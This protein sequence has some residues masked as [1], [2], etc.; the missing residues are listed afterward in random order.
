MLQQ[1]KIGPKFL[2]L[3]T[4]VGLV[5]MAI[6]LWVTYQQNQVQLLGM[7]EM[8]GKVV[9]AQMEA[10]RA[11]IT[12]NYVAKVKAM[13][14][15][16]MVVV[17]DHADNPKAVPLPAT[18][19]REIGE[20]LG[21]D[22]ILT[23]R[24]V[25]ATPLNPSNAPKDGFEEAAMRAIMGGAESYARVE[26]QN[27]EPFYRRATPDK[28]QVAACIGCHT[29]KKIGDTLGILSVSFPMVKAKQFAQDSFV[30][31]AMVLIGMIL[32]ILA[33]M[34]GLLRVVVL[35]PL[36]QM[37]AITHDIAEGEGDL[38]KRVP[39][40]GKD[41]INELAGWM[42][43]FIEKLQGMIGKV[44]HVTDKVAAASVQLSATSEEMAKGADGLTARTAQTAAAVEEMNATVGE[45]AQNS[46]KAASIAQEAVETA[47]SGKDV[48]QETISGMQQLSDAV[49]QSATIIATLGKSSDQ[50]GEIVRVI[51]DIAD[52]TNLLALNAAIEAARAGEQGRGFAV[53]ADEVRK[54]AE[55]TTKATKEIGDMIRHIQQDTKGAVASMDEGTQKVNSGVDLVN[56]TGE[57]LAT[58]A[59][60][61]T[62]TADMI[63]LIAVAAEEQSVA[64]QQISGDLENV[65]KVSKE[66]AGGATESAKASQDLSVLATELQTIVGGFKI[67]GSDKRRG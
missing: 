42:N 41:E 48:V 12:K 43:L 10:T 50:I 39:V 15:S 30:K 56:K 64:T 9:Q 34:Y 31:S 14:K 44:A 18:A 17:K 67:A 65:A 49:S 6:G 32:A 16:E 54:L 13:P 45:V 62:Q 55:R 40:A 61:V 33:A 47:K 24:M 52:Q 21:K 51:E 27:G 57:S 7:L 53:V 25:S 58:I 19:M 38:T 63:R 36:H 35:K 5:V 2:M 20:I 60:R 37:T 8:R 22:G 11:Y 26:E 59:E 4:G 66:S 23:A 3:I 46:G 1:M 28:A 29:D